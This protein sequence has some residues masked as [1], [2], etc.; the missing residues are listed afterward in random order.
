MAFR[1]EAFKRFSGSDNLQLE[2]MVIVPDEIRGVV[3]I[4]H[5]MTEMK[6]RYYPFMEY[7]ADKGFLCVIH[8]M[9]GHGNSIKKDE[10]LGYFY[11]GGYKAIVDDIH[12][13]MNTVK[14]KL[15]KK[16]PYY[17]IGHS[18]G[19]LATRLFMKNYDNEVDKVI[20]LGSP[21]KPHFTEFGAIASKL[22]CNIK[23]RKS[24][25]KIM[26][27]FVINSTYEKPFKKENLQHAWICSD[28]KV[29][30]W[31][32]ANPKCNFCFTSGGYYDLTQLVLEVY[33][34]KDWKMHNPDLPILFIS[35]KD[36]PCHMGPGY[37]GK[38]VRFLKSRG[39]ENV[40]ARLYGG[41]RHEVLN[42]IKK[43]RV[44][45]DIYE[46]LVKE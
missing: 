42:E 35:G 5:G 10:D 14:S 23:G 8:D 46:Y 25:S 22:I 17:L 20:L 36:D 29:V 31:F 33:S 9:R 26:D 37:F 44:Y 38:T 40:E 12:I 2:G 6:E 27:F 18:M 28:K 43:K 15:T 16:V 30:E 41:M 21:S 32:N 39:Y 11:D 13:I 7:L 19:S 45:R 1:Y 34:K 4:A 3:Q 24:H